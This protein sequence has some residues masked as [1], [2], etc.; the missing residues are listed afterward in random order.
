M[1][2]YIMQYEIIWIC[3]FTKL[4]NLITI[5]NTYIFIQAHIPLWI[6]YKIIINSKLDLTCT[7]IYKNYELEFTMKLN[8]WICNL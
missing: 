3:K 7:C 1:W 5:I 2:V 8:I 6:N 4:Y